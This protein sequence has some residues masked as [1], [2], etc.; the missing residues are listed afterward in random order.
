[1]DYE[2]LKNSVKSIKMPEDMKKRVAEKAVQSPEKAVRFKGKLTASLIAAALL[3]VILVSVSAV[4]GG[5]AYELVYA[6]SPS[7]AQHFKSVRKSCTDNGIKME[8]VSSYI[9]GDTAEVYISMQDTTADRVDETTDLFDSYTI[10][11]PFGFDSSGTCSLKSYDSSTKTATFLVTISR[12]DGKEINGGKAT[13]NVRKFLSKKEHYSDIEISL[14]PDYIP[15]NP[16]TH[17]VTLNGVSGNADIDS[18]FEALV[19]KSS[20]ISLGFDGIELTAVG[21]VGGKLHIQASAGDS[22][23]ND[24][25]GEF[26]FKDSNG[27]EIRYTALCHFIE[28]G[29]DGRNDYMEYVF[30]IT[31]EMLKNY[32]L[33]G[34]F[35]ISGELTEG[36]W[37]VTFPLE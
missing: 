13:F 19:P 1:M 21:F 9:H 23:E 2:N 18:P 14:N 6:V 27:S 25:H 11:T 35:V 32:T 22:T 36:N 31:P 30:D 4:S 15:N 7:A 16:Q 28:N 37:E 26:Y 20:F 5:S 24:N 3:V 8:V 12:M 17:P 34:D 29:S 10:R 33:Y